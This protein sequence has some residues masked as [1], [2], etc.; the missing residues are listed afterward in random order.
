[1]QKT[2][3]DKLE[4]FSTKPKPEYKFTRTYVCKT[5]VVATEMKGT[6][7]KLHGTKTKRETG[8]NNEKT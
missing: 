5:P 4:Y 2:I 6:N 8:K 1:M 3:G 7:S